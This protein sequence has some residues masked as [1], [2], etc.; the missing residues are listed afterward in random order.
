MPSS[1]EICALL[2]VDRRDTS[3][4]IHSVLAVNFNFHST[5][6][7]DGVTFNILLIGI[8]LLNLSN[9]SRMEI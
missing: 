5:K 7:G 6:A 9:N 3:I 1:K 8:L 2:D 4:F